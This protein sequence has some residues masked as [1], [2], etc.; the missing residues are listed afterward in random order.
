MVIYLVCKWNKLLF[1]L[2]RRK[3]AIDIEYFFEVFF[4]IT[5]IA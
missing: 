5:H 3:N 4:T 1:L 2:S